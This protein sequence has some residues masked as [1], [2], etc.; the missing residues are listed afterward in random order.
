MDGGSMV[1]GIQSFGHI[2]HPRIKSTGVVMKRTF[3]MT[4]AGAGLGA[5]VLSAQ[6]A[7]PAP[8]STAGSSV[9]H[10]V[11]LTGCLM[12]SGYARFM[13][14]N[15]HVQTNPASAKTSDI[16]LP[17]GQ[18]AQANTRPGMKVMLDATGEL[19]RHIGEIVQI[20]GQSETDL[21]ALERATAKPTEEPPGPLPT[22][23]VESVKTVAQTC[24]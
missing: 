22:I 2:H 14:N 15:A 20:I 11:T 13:L 8:P 7:A 19:G 9:L 3:L 6:T 24:S 16:A 17:P 5:A 10:K 1:G 12:R 23:D 21:A 18:T 4:V